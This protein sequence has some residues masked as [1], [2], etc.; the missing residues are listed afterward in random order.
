MLADDSN[1]MATNLTRREG[2]NAATKAEVTVPI[3]HEMQPR[4]AL[5]QVTTHAAAECDP[6]SLS[7]GAQASHHTHVDAGSLTA[8]TRPADVPIT[9]NPV[10]NSASSL[11]HGHAVAPVAALVQTEASR[12]TVGPILTSMAP[13]A[14]ERNHVE[15]GMSSVAVDYHSAGLTANTQ[16][17]P[18]APSP[19][20]HGGIA[21]DTATA[22]APSANAQAPLQPIPSS[23]ASFDHNPVAAMPAPARR[24]AGKEAVAVLHTDATFH[25]SARPEV[26]VGEI[27]ATSAV[28]VLSDDHAAAACEQIGKIATAAAVNVV[29]D[30][31]ATA[32]S[33][34]KHVD[35]GHA[36]ADTHFPQPALQ[37]CLST[38]PVFGNNQ[39]ADA[40]P[41]GTAAA[42]L[43]I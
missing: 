2:S 24:Q 30:D 22:V 26:L 41:G 23:N 42:L 35:V 37:H 10:L 3:M 39:Q 19:N 5:E 32:A 33:H 27:A 28:K 15:V 1:V 4:T 36:A 13:D 12:A 14:P 29:S 34:G 17:N 8:I 9:G 16:S 11:G 43:D 38:L 21:T 40:L 31:H 25:A 7:A 6:A 18:D 20:A